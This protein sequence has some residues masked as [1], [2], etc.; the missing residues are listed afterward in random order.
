MKLLHD[1]HIF[2]IPGH[3]YR[4]YIISGNDISPEKRIREISHYPGAKRPVWFI[5]SGM[6]SQWAGMG[7]ALLRL[8]VFAKAV[9]KCDNVLKP[10]GIDIYDI[11]TNTDKSIFDKILNS[12]VGIA[13]VQI[14]LVDLLNS[15]NIIPD[16]II[17]HSVGELGC[18]Y[19]DGCFTAEQM[20]LAAYSRGLASLEANTI[21]GSM[22]AVGLGYK[23]VKNLCPPDIEVACHNGPESSTISGPAESMKAFVAELQAKNIFAREV[24]C[25]NIAYHSRYIADAG[26][27]LLKYLSEVIPEP[28][29]RSAKWVSTSVPQAQWTTAKARY[30]S[31]EYHT[32]N[33]LSAVLFEETSTIIPKDAVTIEIAPHG[34][35]Q[36]IIK[37]SLD[38]GVI[39]I[40]LTQ[41][42]H[43]DNVEIFLQAIGKLYNVGLQP[44]IANLYPE[45]QLPVSR[46]T[47][48]I[49][50]II[51]WDHSDD[52]YVT[53]YK[54]Q[55]KITSGERIIEL[56]LADDDYQ[57]MAGHVIDGRNLL[58]ATGYLVF[59]WQTVGLMK[60]ELYTEISV[61]F[62][63]VK[64]LRATTLPKEGIIELTVVVQKGTGRFEIVEG[65]V[66]VVTGYIHTTLN[67]NMEKMNLK[68]PEKNESDE[69]TCKDFYKE[70]GLRGYN[71]DG[72]FKGVKSAT[73]N[74]SRG[75]IAW[76]D[77]WVAF[78]D[79]M[80]QI[81]ILGI[82][83]RSLC[84]PTGI[85]KLVIDTTT[86]FNQ[87]RAM[88]KNNKGLKNRII[89]TSIN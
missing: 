39:N 13:A 10:H 37:R 5:F 2:D 85:Q 31:A 55:K 65:G 50:P 44:L 43:K 51:K 59:V 14:G 88:P 60:G 89:I 69:M 74:G 12:F 33:L 78:M 82:D 4:G 58:P 29:P 42:G 48:M 47:P 17:G 24:P 67:P 22:A 30:S 53:S 3:L 18:A 61:V 86:H 11:L 7:S 49:S 71:Y 21:R 40:P 8:P 76:S 70:L 87:I 34:L 64:F 9:K 41:R 81:Q 52:W 46:G 62:Q 23:D 56:S 75:T 16:Y 27:K 80:L 1:I 20:V 73:T 66:A 25:S 79:N 28:K 38:P 6:G 35:L 63:D 45:V 32:N 19:A 68:L 36:A 26:P 57:Y 83:S 15:L 72:L 84:V 54:T 77:N